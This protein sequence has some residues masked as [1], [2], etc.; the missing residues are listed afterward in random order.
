M[1]ISGTA[2]NPQH[3]RIRGAE[4]ARHPQTMALS[5]K[6]RLTKMVVKGGK[7]MATMKQK[8]YSPDFIMAHP[9]EES[10]LDQDMQE[11][12]YG[13]STLQFFLCPFAYVQLQ[14]ENTAPLT[15]QIV[16]WWEGAAQQLE[17]RGA[18]L[19]NNCLM[20]IS[21]PSGCTGCRDWWGCRVCRM[22]RLVKMQCAQGAVYNVGAY[23]GEHH[24]VRIVQ[25]NIPQICTTDPPR[26]IR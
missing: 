1:G 23:Q 21:R 22:Q 5:R 20:A 9:L 11:L 16:V 7:D 3:P 4:N 15:K 12:R 2:S 18:E 17:A 13:V 14:E 19:A 24:A 25:V 26:C 10:C 6:L 8:S